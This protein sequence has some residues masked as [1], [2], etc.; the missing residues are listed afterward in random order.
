MPTWDGDKG[1]IYVDKPVNHSI[2]KSGVEV[3]P[4][5]EF[6][7]DIDDHF[8]K[9]GEELKMKFPREMWAGSLRSNAREAQR[10]VVNSKEEYTDFIKTYNGK[11][12]VFTS[13]YD[14]EFFTPNRGL[15]YSVI[16]DRIF[17]DFDAHGD[18]E[19][20]PELY[21]DV[22]RMHKRKK[23]TLNLMMMSSFSVLG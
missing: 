23:A 3:K 7:F 21:Q 8:Q 5:R 22:I 10:I 6:K 15:E 18:K 2:V 19:S 16:L 9:G 1:V 13:V 17:L 11:M 14:Y 20:L 12:N 4:L